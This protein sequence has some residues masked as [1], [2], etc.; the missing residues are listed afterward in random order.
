MGR[1][2]LRLSNWKYL[3]REY[4]YVLGVDVIFSHT[5]RQSIDK[6]ENFLNACLDSFLCVLY[7]TLRGFMAIVG[8]ASLS[9]YY[10]APKENILMVL[11]Q[12]PASHGL[13][14]RE[15]GHSALRVV[16]SIVC[17]VFYRWE[18]TMDSAC[19]ILLKYLRVQ[20]CHAVL[21][22]D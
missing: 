7:F 4:V 6:K 2:F 13:Q 22:P 16:L 17:G 3:L 14:M 15:L 10:L 20:L 19:Q 8:V 12:E 11:A 9:Q 5:R 1:L 18:S 21:N